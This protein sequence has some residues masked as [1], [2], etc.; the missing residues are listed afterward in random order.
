MNYKIGSTN[1][2]FKTMIFLTLLSVGVIMIYLFM[3]GG[4]TPY[5]HF[6]LL[7][8][9]LLKGHLYIN[10]EYP[11]LEKV[12]VDEN[13]FYVVNPPMPAVIAMPFVLLFGKNF[14]QQY[15]AHMI[16][17]L[18]SIIFFRISLK[19]KMNTSLAVWSFL[20]TSL[21]TIIFYLSSVGSVWYLGQ[22]TGCLFLSLAILETL[23]KKRVFLISLLL[24]FA[25]LSRIQLIVS[26]PFFIYLLKDDLM[27]KRFYFFI[28]GISVFAIIY[29][30][31]N[32]LRFGNIF[33]AGYT[34]IPGIK[35]EPW[36]N[37]GPFSLSYIPNHLKIIFG[38]LPKISKVFPYILPTLTGI[39]IWFTTPAFL[40]SF[41][42]KIKSVKNIFI[43]LSIL[44]IAFINFSYG[45]V[46]IS[47]FG[48]RYA[49]DFYP[50]LILLTIKGVA[51]KNGPKWYHWILLVMGMIV[52][53]W[54]V[55]W[56]N[57]FGWV[58]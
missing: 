58:G 14:P 38:G 12:P 25:F 36:F 7:A 1:K 37:K 41:A 22:I 27:S 17:V 31:Y 28:A 40:F 2:S 4:N 15:I 13:T 8:D 57:K 46:G 35:S 55:L 10:G 52:N 23:T 54:G 6:T 5:N 56:I 42:N 20:L 48:Y 44:L 34:M 33:E 49:V 47:Q 9:S 11:W 39:A 19:I 29:G 26:L 43:W 21:G 24:S 45:S 18:I 32:F 53:L 51:I 30:A 50:F 3:S 16:G